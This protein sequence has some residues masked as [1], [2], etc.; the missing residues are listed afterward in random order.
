MVF[1]V[2]RAHT[3]VLIAF[4]VL[5]KGAMF[6]ILFHIQTLSYLQVGGT[7]ILFVLVYIKV[8]LVTRNDL[9]ISKKI[10]C[11]RFINNEIH[12]SIKHA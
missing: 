9:Y 6:H 12:V 8:N 4:D 2:K 3:K 5:N 11:Y 1:T 10:Q 7:C